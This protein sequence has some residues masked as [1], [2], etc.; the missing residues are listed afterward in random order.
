MPVVKM[1]KNTKP[2]RHRQDEKG[3]W[4]EGGY[5]FFMSKVLGGGKRN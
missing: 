2:R 3:D 1:G 5:A 4:I